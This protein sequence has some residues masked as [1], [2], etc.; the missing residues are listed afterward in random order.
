MEKLSIYVVRFS[1]RA[2]R[3]NR[4]FLFVIKAY[5][6]PFLDTFIRK[7]ILFFFCKLENKIQY[8]YFFL[9]KKVWVRYATNHNN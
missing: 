4:Y 3:V 6:F 7:I 8:Q 1:L 2:D 5:N 9:I